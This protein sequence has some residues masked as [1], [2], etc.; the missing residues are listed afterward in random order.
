MAHRLARGPVVIGN[1]YRDALQAQNARYEDS[2]ALP[3]G[4][5]G[6]QEYRDYFGI[7]DCVPALKREDRV[8]PKSHLISGKAEQAPADVVTPAEA[9]VLSGAQL[10]VLAL[11]GDY[12]AKDEIVRR[13]IKRAGV[14]A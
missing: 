2:T 9:F 11:A 12:N 10:A 1:A 3:I 13:W 6:R 8:T 14:A 7:G 4:D 5:T